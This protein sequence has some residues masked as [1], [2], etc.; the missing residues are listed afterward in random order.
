MIW[1]PI[2][3]APKDGR[4]VW[5]RGDNWG[6]PGKGVHCCWAWWDEQEGDW[7]EEGADALRLKY[8]KEWLD[9][10]EEGGK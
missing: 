3:T 6:E 1:K 2:D 7:I 4:P 9:M 5:V 10:S 8:L